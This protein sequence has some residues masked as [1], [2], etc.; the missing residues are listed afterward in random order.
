MA[1]HVITASEPTSTPPST[2]SSKTDDMATGTDRDVEEGVLVWTGDTCTK[3]APVK[4]MATHLMTSLAAT[5]RPPPTSS[6]TTADRAATN[7][8]DTEK[9]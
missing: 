9:D 3:T 5:T 6:S 4:M 8:R 7:D 1:T 2:L